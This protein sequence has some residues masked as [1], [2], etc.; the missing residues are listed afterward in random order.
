MTRAAE[1]AD[2]SGRTLSVRRLGRVEYGEALALQADLVEQRRLGTIPDTL[3]LL[4]HSHVVTLGSSARNKH[5]L[6][7]PD[8]LAS[9][10][11][12]V[13]RTGR[14]GDVT[15]HGPGQLVGYPILD[16]KPDRKDL[17][18]YL[19]GVEGVLLRVLAAFGLEGQRESGATGVW[20]DGA[21]AAAVGVRVSSGWI[22]S[23]GFALNAN[24]DLSYFSAIVPCGIPGRPV[25]SLSR[26]LGRRVTPW[27]AADMV[28]A[29]MAEEFGYRRVD[30]PGERRPWERPQPAARTRGT[31]GRAADPGAPEA[32]GDGLGAG[33]A[34]RR[35]LAEVEE[36]PLGLALRV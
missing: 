33:P 18:A 22:A 3:L 6:L 11:I 35:R 4:E 5:V 28:G 36:A 9:R 16:L 21:K 30:D 1:R 31:R 13:Y 25:T 23:H 15:Y 34:R 19:R 24:T 20:V 14:G 32:A 2:W 29:A 17:H 7:G 27:D 26:L 12:A 8:E 10:N